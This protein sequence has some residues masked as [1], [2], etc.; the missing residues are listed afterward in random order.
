MEYYK[1]ARKVENKQRLK[2]AESLQRTS[3]PWFCIASHALWGKNADNL[4]YVNAQN[5]LNQVVIFSH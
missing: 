3:S 2:T 1:I 4:I 5:Y